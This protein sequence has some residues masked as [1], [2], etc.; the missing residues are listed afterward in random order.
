LDRN[1]V[2]SEETERTGGRRDEK[3]EGCDGAQQQSTR[4]AWASTANRRRLEHRHA[5]NIAIF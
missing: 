2:R 1:L 3:I 5:I 4:S